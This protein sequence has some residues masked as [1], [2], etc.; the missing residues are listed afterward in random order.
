MWISGA[1]QSGVRP[2]EHRGKHTLL[3]QVHTMQSHTRRGTNTLNLKAENKAAATSA[4]LMPS[5]PS[6]PVNNSSLLSFSEKSLH[7]IKQRVMED[8]RGAIRQILFFL[9]APQ[10][11]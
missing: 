8:R 3:L 7:N 10:K 4:P 11:V 6:L 1:S 2:G 5:S 9:T